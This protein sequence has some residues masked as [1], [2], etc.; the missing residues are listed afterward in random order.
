M[1]GK[2]GIPGRD[3]KDGTPGRAG[4]QSAVIASQQLLLL[5]FFR[6]NIKE[7]ERKIELGSF[8]FCRNIA[9]TKSKRES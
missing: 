5:F 9:A 6:R 8:P 2:N 4:E 1:P 7:T 3:G